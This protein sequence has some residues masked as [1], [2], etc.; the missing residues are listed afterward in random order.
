MKKDY[1]VFFF[2]FLV[3]AFMYVV[4]LNHFLLFHYLIET[5]TIIVSFV[6]FMASAITNKI[7]P[8]SFVR[9]FSG[10]LLSYALM[11][12][13]YTLTHE[14]IEVFEVSGINIT[15]SIWIAANYILSLSILITA[16]HIN[17]PFNCKLLTVVY[18]SLA[19]IMT[20]SILSGYFPVCYIEGTGF[21]FFK[22]MSEVII[23]LALMVSMYQ[24]YKKREHFRDLMFNVLM[25]SF[26]LFI[27]SEVVVALSSESHLLLYAFGHLLRL[28]GLSVIFYAV[29]T[30]N[31][32][33][34]FSFLNRE[35]IIS[36]EKEQ[37][38]SHLL[39]ENYSRL[40]H[41]QALAKT[42]SWELD[43]EL[44]LTYGSPEAYRL[45]GLDSSSPKMYRLS[46][47][48]DQFVSK[49]DQAKLSIGIANLI[50]EGTYFDETIEIKDSDSNS[51][52]LRSFATKQY[53]ASGENMKIIGST[54]D[55]TKTVEREKKLVYVSYHDYLTKLYNRRFFE[56]ELKRLDTSRNWPLTIIMGDVNGL[57][58]F[59]D[60]FG[61]SL[62]DELLKKVA[63]IFRDSFRADDI[64][65]RFGGDEFA[66]LLPK[67]SA[68][69]AEELI[70]RITFI[71]SK[72]KL[73]NLPVSISFGYATKKENDITSMDLIKTAE[74][75]MLK[76]KL[77][78]GKSS[79][80]RAIDAL[81]ATL[82]EK[83]FDSEQH[84][85]RVSDFAYLLA[86]ALGETN[87]KANEIKAAAL[88]HDIG[89]V[90]ISN[91]IL[92]KKDKLTDEEFNKI[93]MHPVT[94]YKILKSVG[95]MINL[96]NYTLYHHERIDGKG[97]PDGLKGKD[98]PYESKIL[99][100]CD[101]YDAMTSFRSYKKKLSKEEAIRELQKCANKQ[102]D[103]EIVHVFVSKVLMN[104]EI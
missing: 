60:A 65:A 43:S 46:E 42:G 12:I 63:E 80:S 50:T 13:M 7:L 77:F 16:F 51:K 56:E 18:L 10:G 17:K 59:N 38:Q 83:D 104:N 29:I 26:T 103:A 97:Y 40:L 94:G 73:R 71:T 87:S 2:I 11:I 67:G 74:E 5:A 101:S 68:E 75:K 27:I 9:R 99:S 96:A 23:I 33:D 45:F 85:T 66:I 89:K 79:R 36:S 19:L 69:I 1:V 3:F 76:A 62:G 88:L 55:V 31:V 84:S 93:K 32:R 8:V 34:P 54:Q 15:T 44:N 39:E 70:A 47:I 92:N 37:K 90:T 14:G 25:I 48:L 102:F 35:V 20:Y 95:S 6:I 81:M 49:K 4:S 91:E 61:Y 22:T 98:I 64:I 28:T 58:G 82:Y 41:S 78:E 24:V 72:T 100:I 30:I 86:I 57:K 52:Y 21:T 53:D